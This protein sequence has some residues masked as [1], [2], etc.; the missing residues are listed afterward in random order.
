MLACQNEIV[1]KSEFFDPWR[2]V[3]PPCETSEEIA[4]LRTS[5]DFD[6]QILLSLAP[7]KLHVIKSSNRDDLT[8]LMKRL[9][10]IR[11]DENW[12]LWFNGKPMHRLDTVTLAR[13]FMFI[14]KN[15]ITFSPENNIEQELL[16]SGKSQ[17]IQSKIALY[18]EFVNFGLAEHM[19][20][21]F[22]D[23][24]Q[25][26][27]ILAALFHAV[28]RLPKLIVIN[29]SLDKLSEKACSQSIK[30]LKLAIS[31]GSTVILGC[32]SAKPQ[33]NAYSVIIHHH[34]EKGKILLPLN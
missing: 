20:K 4:S 16:H 1:E 17:S 15:D 28:S 5:D 7:K 6:G 33:L 10:G 18:E 26:Q 14:D 27:K 30:L 21:A 12:V 8:T 11:H 3:Y 32:T 2:F 24:T 34:F 31:K 25:E 9:S 22:S 19:G 13:N 29:Q 23:L